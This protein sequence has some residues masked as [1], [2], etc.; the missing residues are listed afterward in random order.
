MSFYL[1]TSLVVTALTNERRTRE[2]L[3]WLRP[4]SPSTLRISEWVVAEFSAALSIKQR[5]RKL[6]SASRA[7]TLQKFKEFITGELEIVVVATAHFRT[8]AAFADRYDLG[9]RAGDA[10]HLAIASE[11][12]ATLCTLDDDLAVAAPHF[13]VSVI[14]L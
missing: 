14:H 9:L 7:A 4:R 5:M 1:D 6:D 8:A 11:Q 2:V 12:G 10:L 13:G 3:E